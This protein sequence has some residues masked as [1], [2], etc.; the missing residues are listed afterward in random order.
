VQLALKHKYANRYLNRL[1]GKFITGS[2]D[3]S[4]HK[5]INQSINRICI[6]IILC[7]VSFVTCVVLCAVFCLSVVCYFV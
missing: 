7:S 2:N 1:T 6:V 3:L 4:S 5:F